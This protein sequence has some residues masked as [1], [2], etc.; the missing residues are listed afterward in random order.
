MRYSKCNN[1]SKI[2]IRL[3]SLN[4]HKGFI[5][6]VLYGYINGAC[7]LS[8]SRTENLKKGAAPVNN[9]DIID[10]IQTNMFAEIGCGTYLATC[11]SVF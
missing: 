5:K 8:L 1:F 2:E 6:C 10:L 3:V 11:R 9:D 4:Q 7:T